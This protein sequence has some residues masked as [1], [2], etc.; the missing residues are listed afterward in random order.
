MRFCVVQL[1]GVLITA[2]NAAGVKAELTLLPDIGIHGNSHMLLQDKNNL[3]IADRL[4]GWINHHVG[5]KQ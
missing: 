3:I 1:V 2:A 5:S 4:V